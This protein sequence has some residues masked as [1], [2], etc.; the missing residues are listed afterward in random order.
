MMRP[1]WMVLGALLLTLG[2]APAWAVLQGQEGA[3]EP[4]PVLRPAEV[5]RLLDAYV[6]LQAQ[7]ALQLTEAQY[8]Q[9]LTKLRAFQELRRRNEQ[10]RL[11]LINELNRVSNGRVAAEG[12]DPQLRERLKALDDLELSSASDLRRARDELLQTLDVRQQARF[13]VFEEQMER[14][15]LELL[16]RARA[17]RPRQQRP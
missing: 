10:S 14:R 13:R 7:E 12:S 2:T 15:K 6:V 3:G 9:F 16:V 4:G 17:A 8:P 1:R 11:K 5:Q